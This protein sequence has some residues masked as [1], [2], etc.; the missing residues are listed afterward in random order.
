MLSSGWIEKV[1]KVDGIFFRTWSRSPVSEKTR[2]LFVIHGLGEQSDRY[3][4]FTRFLPKEFSLIIA[5]DLPGHGMSEGPRGHIEKFSDYTEAAVKIFKQVQSQQPNIE[6]HWLGHS[7]GG[8][9]TLVALST[10][11]ELTLKSCVL[12]AP[13]L[14]VSMPV[15]LLK[16]M[17]AQLINP[18]LGHFPVANEIDATLLTH[19]KE[20]IQ[21]YLSNPLNHNLVTPR[22]FIESTRTCKNMNSLDLTLNYNVAFVVPI[23]EKIVSNDA[24]FSFFKKLKMAHG[25]KKVLYTFP[26]FYHESFQELGKERAFNAIAEFFILLEPLSA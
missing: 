21:K 18:I 13:Y 2:A 12:S 19:D 3:T 26:G 25:K 8:L 7:L 6:W 14:G 11:T 22:F 16:K 24:T 20:E 4:H 10:H 1:E 5:M 23:E 9:V 17:F 15:P